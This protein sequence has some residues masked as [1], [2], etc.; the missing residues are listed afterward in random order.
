MKHLTLHRPWHSLMAAF[1][2]PLLAFLLAC[3]PGQEPTPTPTA[4]PKPAATPTATATAA[5][6]ATATPTRPGPAATPTPT[7]VAVA[8]PTPTPGEQPKRGGTLRYA[9][10]TFTPTFDPQLLSASPEYYRTNGKLYLN[11]FV[12]YVGQETQCEICSDKGWRLEDSGKTMVFDLLPGIKFHNGQEL[13]SADVAYSLKMI[14]GE[15]DGIVSPRAGVFREY[16]KSIEAPSKYGVRINLLRPSPFVPKIL[17]IS[18]AAIY[19]EGTTR[20]DLKKADSGAGPFI[21]K[22]VIQGAT[23]QLV[24]YPDYFK[25]GQPYI[26]VFETT[27]IPD[28]NTRIAAFLTHKIE[29]GGSPSKT[30]EAKLTQL[31]SEG[32]IR[33]VVELGGCGQRHVSFNNQKPPY[34]D[35]RMRQAVNLLLDRTAIATIDMGSEILPFVAS[36]MFY[37][38]GTEYATPAEKI[39]NVIPGWGTG[40]KKQEEQEKAKQLVLAA[41]Y[42]NGLDID[43]MARV[44]FNNTYAPEFIQQELKKIG[45]RT[46]ISI[47][48]PDQIAERQANLDYQM[49]SYNYCATTRDPDEA[50]GNYWITGGSRNWFGYSNPEVDKLYV[51]MSSEQDPIKRKELFFKIQDI[52]VVKDTAWAPLADIDGLEWYWNNF[53]GDTIG[54]SI[55]SASGFH[56]GDR[57]WLDQ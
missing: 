10:G 6:A 14:T 57:L 19:R 7:S 54:M 24:R 31:E 41:G 44:P 12:N 11:L 2:I 1:L 55:H 15:V 34:N 47:A 56:R 21:V 8:T 48:L 50:I 45:I 32:K 36:L 16:L 9:N 4:T 3:G 23:W 28:T 18:S 30:Y 5:P 46:K 52:I 51:Q 33:R 39:W 29:W 22:N 26:D 40:A 53:H 17:A 38:P 43:Q 42:P 20:E 37:H 27:T 25:K 13:T 35:I 49:Q